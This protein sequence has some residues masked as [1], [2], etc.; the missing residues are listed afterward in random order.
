MLCSPVRS[1][2]SRGAVGGSGSG[3][4]D[5]LRVK[6]SGLDF[7]PGPIHSCPFRNASSHWAW[8]SSCA[9]KGSGPAPLHLLAHHCGPISSFAQSP[10]EEDTQRG[11]WLLLLLWPQI[12]P[13]GPSLLPSSCPP[14][15]EAHPQPQ[16]S[17]F[18]VSGPIYCTPTAA[19][20]TD[21]TC[22]RVSVTEI[23]KTS[24]LA[25][26]SFS[27]SPGEDGNQGYSHRVG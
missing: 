3:T 19:P 1:Y 25:G 8:A 22:L 18:P 4:G 15:L 21:H 13:L 11:H 9:C 23:V 26:R 12:F 2:L 10:E 27:V 24:N 16:I 17:P 5:C 14:S 7:L 6:G 20:D